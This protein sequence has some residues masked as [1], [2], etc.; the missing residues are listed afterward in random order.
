MKTIAIAAA[1]GGATKTTIT[2]VLAVQASRESD[3][4]LMIDLNAD[5]GNLTQW[6]ASRGEPD[7]PGLARNVEN[8]P[9]DVKALAGGKFDWLLIDTP[10]IEMDLIEQ[11][12]AVA[13]AVVIPV[14]T[15]IFDVNSIDP[16]VEMCRDHRKPYAFLLSAVD[17]KFK[18]LTQQTAAALAREGP[19]FA[20]RISYK[21]AYIQA[22]THG[23][24]G[25]EIAKDLAPEAEALWAEVKQL[26]TKGQIDG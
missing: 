15:S 17:G 7:V 13:D 25:A 8:L 11:A 19:M 2:S 3:K 14:R 6:W 22:L 26:A 1:K 20:A 9:Q 18:T 24:T 21:L 5:Q 23:K 4:V 16:V 12:I 10:P